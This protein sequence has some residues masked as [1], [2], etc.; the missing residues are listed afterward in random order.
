MFRTERT[1]RL[2]EADAD[3]RLRLDA[4]ARYLGDVAEDG[5]DDAGYDEH[6]GWLVRRTSMTMRCH[7]GA[8]AGRV[9]PVPM[10]AAPRSSPSSAW[11]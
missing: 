2:G 7:S 11:R 1:V 5:V 10:P 8:C 9:L 3:G 6:T 4:I